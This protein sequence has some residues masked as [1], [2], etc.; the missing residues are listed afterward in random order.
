MK[1]N[2]EEY[3]M[4]Q[5]IKEDGM[6]VLDDNLPDAFNDWFED[7]EKEDIMKY[8]VKYDEAIK[9]D[10][11]KW[12]KGLMPKVNHIA[13]NECIKKILINANKPN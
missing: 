2:F 7:T 3:L 12:V 4:E 11:M 1:I 6:T 13:W 9:E 8:A 5:F 10:R